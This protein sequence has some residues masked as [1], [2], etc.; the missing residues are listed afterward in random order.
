MNRLIIKQLWGGGG[1]SP[2][3]QQVV[4]YIC[5]RIQTQV[6]GG[7]RNVPPTHLRF[8][9]PLRYPC[10]PVDIF[11][12]TILNPVRRHGRRTQCVAKGRHV[13]PICL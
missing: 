5:R 10:V 6:R 4:T 8:C 7:D 12:H 1:A 13:K 3:Y 9:V 2:Y 11:L